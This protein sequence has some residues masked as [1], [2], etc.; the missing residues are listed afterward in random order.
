LPVG[1]GDGV[2]SQESGRRVN[3]IDRGVM[4]KYSDDEDED[5][6]EHGSG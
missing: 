2:R 1:E 4:S 6:E 5:D 3:V